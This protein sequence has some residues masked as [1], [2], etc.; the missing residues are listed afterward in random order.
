[1]ADPESPESQRAPI[2]T[3]VASQS[4]SSVCLSVGVRASEVTARTNTLA[5]LNGL[6]FRCFIK[7]LSCLAAA[8]A[9]ASSSRETN[10]LPAA[11]INSQPVFHGLALSSRVQLIS[12]CSTHLF[13]EPDTKLLEK[14]FCGRVCAKAWRKL[15]AAGALI[16]M[17][18][19]VTHS[20]TRTF[21]YLRLTGLLAGSPAD[22][23]G[24]AAAAAA[25]AAE[26]RTSGR[27][28]QHHQTDAP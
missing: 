25:A 15:P 19:R 22:G 23:T 12:S 3:L 9:A 27:L 16:E 6:S 10:C 24:K 20:L 21:L 11:S 7:P 5:G 17:S 8:A 28:K 18:R 13:C 14:K 26:G 1:M 4:L 2:S